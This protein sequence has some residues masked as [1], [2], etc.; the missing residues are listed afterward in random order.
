[1][2][3][4]CKKVGETVDEGGRLRIAIEVV[5]AASR[6]VATDVFCRGRSTLEDEPRDRQRG[7]ESL[8]GSDLSPR[9]DLANPFRSQPGNLRS[10]PD[11]VVVWAVGIEPGSAV[12]F[13]DNRENYRERCGNSQFSWLT[14]PQESAGNQR[15]AGPIPCSSEQGICHD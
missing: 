7:A 9:G 6:H 13:R 14:S 1:M 5:A 3:R 10:A 2:Q 12:K 8:A 15:L 11:C 4:D